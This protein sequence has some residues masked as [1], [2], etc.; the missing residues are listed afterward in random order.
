MTRLPAKCVL[1]ALYY[2]VG[3]QSPF[4]RAERRFIAV[5]LADFYL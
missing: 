2:P 1:G 4:D 5:D 3:P